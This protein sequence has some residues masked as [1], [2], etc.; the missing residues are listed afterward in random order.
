MTLFLLENDFYPV[1]LLKNFLSE[2][3]E[4]VTNRHF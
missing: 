1:D 2:A 4:M 3:E